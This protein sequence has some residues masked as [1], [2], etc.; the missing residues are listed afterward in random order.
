MRPTA[1]NASTYA[2]Y[3]KHERT[4]V[5]GNLVRFVDA[6]Y[7]TMKVSSQTHECVIQISPFVDSTLLNYAADHAFDFICISARGAGIMEKLFGTTTTNL[8]NQSSV[9][10]MAVPANYRAAKLTSIL[11]ASDLSSLGPELKEVIAVAKPLAATVELRHFSAPSE[12]V[13]DPAIIQMAVQKFTDYP[14]RVHL[15]ARNLSITLTDDIEQAVR[16]VKPSMLLMFTRQNEGFFKRLFLSGN[17]I[18][19]SFLTTV[20]LLVFR[21]A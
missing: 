18:D 5:Q 15:Q 13:T 17:S 21:K 2:S 10:V 6:V 4:K 19:C 11:Y 3:E 20:P 8:I 9:P 12:P 14:V 1:W 16:T 7:K